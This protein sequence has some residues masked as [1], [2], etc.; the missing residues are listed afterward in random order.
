MS[1]MNKD[2]KILL[3]GGGW[4]SPYGDTEA[5]IKKNRKAGQMPNAPDAVRVGGPAYVTGTQK[6]DDALF[7]MLGSIGALAGEAEEDYKAR[8]RRKRKPSK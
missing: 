5:E 7:D 1:V 2:G 6:G 3:P 8:Q 4:W